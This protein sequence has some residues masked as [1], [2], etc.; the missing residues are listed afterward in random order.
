MKLKIIQN[1]SGQLQTTLRAVTKFKVFEG[2]LSLYC[3]H[4]AL[5]TIY[6]FYV[7]LVSMVMGGNNY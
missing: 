3:K 5:L 2:H 1:H 6:I 7:T 4:M